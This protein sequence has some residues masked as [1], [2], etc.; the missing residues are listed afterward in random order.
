[1]RSRSENHV[2]WPA[3]FDV[4]RSRADGRMVAKRVAVDEPKCEEI[5]AAAQACGFEGEIDADAA[6]PGEWQKA[7][8]RV[9]LV[10]QGS[11][12]ELLNKVAGELKRMRGGEPRQ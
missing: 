4:K 1:L 10:R 5:L 6:Y 11:K 7:G 8:G 9:R 2:L 12:S 3:Y